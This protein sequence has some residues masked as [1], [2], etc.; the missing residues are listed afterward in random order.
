M[1]FLLRT[2]LITSLLYV[3]LVK[4]VADYFSIVCPC[5]CIKEGYASKTVVDKSLVFLIYVLLAWLCT[6]RKVLL[7]HGHAK[8][9]DKWQTLIKVQIKCDE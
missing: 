5:G 1:S 7:H 6:T 9:N 2:L 3:L 8:S 4:D